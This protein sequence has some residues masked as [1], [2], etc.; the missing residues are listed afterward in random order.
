MRFIAGA[1]VVLAGS[2]LWG[3][4]ASAVSWAQVAKAN[5][6]DATMAT[7]GGMAVVA[8]GLVILVMAHTAPLD[9]Q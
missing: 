3:I 7:Y 9:R 2:L 8:A 5:V 6:G 4:G 1:I